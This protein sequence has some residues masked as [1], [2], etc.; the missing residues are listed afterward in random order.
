M[1]RKKTAPASPTFCENTWSNNVKYHE[2]TLNLQLLIKT[3]Y[4]SSTRYKHHHRSFPTRIAPC[5]DHQNHQMGPLPKKNIRTP[6]L[7]DEITSCWN[8][9]PLNLSLLGTSDPFTVRRTGGVEQNPYLDS[10]RYIGRVEGSKIKATGWS[11]KKDTLV[12][13]L[14]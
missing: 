6:R 13:A 5:F 1:I 14:H 9:D 11:N 2:F 10:T 7:H 8:S 4:H 12:Y 3:Y